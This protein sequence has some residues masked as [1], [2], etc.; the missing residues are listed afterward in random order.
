MKKRSHTYVEK[1]RK[2]KRAAYSQSYGYRQKSNR[3]DTEPDG[4]TEEVDGCAA[5]KTTVKGS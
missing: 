3:T 4:E 2:C 1:T 5:V